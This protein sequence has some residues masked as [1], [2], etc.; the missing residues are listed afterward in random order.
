MNPLSIT[1]Y[2]DG[3]PGHEK[4]TQ[5]ILNGLSELTPIEVAVVNISVAPAA[6]LKDWATY[7][8]P[9]FQGVKQGEILPPADIIIGTGSHTHIPMLLDKKRRNR[10]S[11]DPVRVICC[12]TPDALLRNKFD[13][14][15]IPMHDTPALKE[16]VFVTQG[17]PATVKFEGR[18]KEE[19]GLILVGGLDK[20]SHVW[21]SA[22]IVS[23]IQIIIDKN[24]SIQWTVSSSPRTPEDTCQ[25]LQDQMYSICPGHH[26]VS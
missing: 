16:N 18:H 5:G 1:A 25:M 8:F 26:Q 3:R 17:P 24:P 20:K 4:Q 15:F 22:E 12:M 11:C 2:F 6:Y 21:R 7:I 10:S 23:R 19:K 14:C 13:L 9:F